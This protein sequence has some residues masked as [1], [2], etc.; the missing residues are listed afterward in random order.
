MTPGTCRSSLIDL[1]DRRSCRRILERGVRLEHHHRGL[2]RSCRELL[3]EQVERLL[4]VGVRKVERLAE[5]A[6][7]AAGDDVDPDQ[8]DDPADQGSPSMAV[9]DVRHALQHPEMLS[10]SASACRSGA[11]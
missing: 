10:E 8:Q 11:A 6:A 1:V 2:A 7:H 3:V 4:R 5:A 9:A